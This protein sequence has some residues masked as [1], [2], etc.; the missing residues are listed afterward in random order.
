MRMSAMMRVD[1]GRD[2]P[3][4]NVY[5]N[6]ALALF[7]IACC[8]TCQAGTLTGKR[9]L[10]STDYSSPSKKQATGPRVMEPAFSNAG[11]AAGVE[12]WRIEV[13]L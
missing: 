8:A 13:I 11:S 5:R 10:S 9:P 3:S 7:V 6:T 12:I 4:Q 2:S 1:R